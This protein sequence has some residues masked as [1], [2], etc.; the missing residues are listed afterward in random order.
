MNNRGHL[1]AGQPVQGGAGAADNMGSV[2]VAGGPPPRRGGRPQHYAPAHA[3][4]NHHHQQHVAQPLYATAN[5]MAAPYGGAH[6][7]MHPPYQNGGMPAP[8][9]YMPYPNGGYVRSPAAAMQHF[10]PLQQA[11]GRPPQHSPIVS[12]PYHPPP[13]TAASVIP[14]MP[15]TPSSTHSYVVP[16]SMTPPVQQQLYEPPHPV[17]VPVQAQL[18]QQLD[19]QPEP[20]LAPRPQQGLYV[21]QHEFV[22]QAKQTLARAASP[23]RQPFRPPVSSQNPAVE[24]FCHRSSANSSQLPWLSV[25]ELP[26]PQRTSRLKKKKALGAGAQRLELPGQ[27]APAAETKEG[28]PATVEQQAASSP[29]EPSRDA[30]VVPPRSATPST[31]GQRSEDI[32]SSSPTTPISSVQPSQASAA[33][34]VTAATKSVAPAVP[35]IP[36]VPVIPALPKASSK[37]AKTTTGTEN[38][39]AESGPAGAAPKQ[40]PEATAPAA[41]TENG[42]VEVKTSEAAPPAPAWSKPKMWAGLF[43]PSTS[44]AA[45]TSSAATA[46]Q[47]STNG[48]ATEGPDAVPG[49]GSFAKA[50][51]SSLAQALQAYRPVS[52]DKLAFL[53][54]RGLVNTGNMC[55]MNSVRLP[56][57]PP[58]QVQFSDSR[59]RCYKCSSSPYLSMTSWIRSARRPF[60]A[61]RA[62]RRWWMPCKYSAVCITTGLC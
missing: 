46:T 24:R 9:A 60:T 36:A 23:A 40:Q 11:Y 6:Y 1:P 30:E 25:P 3:Y 47:T 22:P 13:P 58:H 18:P 33:A 56:L 57:D 35:A 5:Y 2:P 42:T 4:G 16:P 17:S 27:H 10:V 32:V 45:S 54:P 49:A 62:R 31:Q 12:S 41:E 14:P 50:N 8:A 21:P 37:E 15:H 28:Q 7:Y 29:E 51:A 52:P 20:Q 19:L 34:S 43:K 61:S 44:G 26:F 38:L 59:S 55:Y 53:E 39:S 48:N